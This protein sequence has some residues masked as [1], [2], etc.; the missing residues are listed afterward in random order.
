MHL[1][2]RADANPEIGTGHVM[3]CLALAQA[4]RAQGG[5][6]TFFARLTSEWLQARLADA[7]LA[8]QVPPVADGGPDDATATIDLAVRLGA[9]MVVID[10]YGFG[11]DYQ[12]RLSA[13]GL[14]LLVIDDHVYAPHYCCDILLNQNLH[15]ESLSYSCE[16]TTKLL[17][18]PRFALLREE[19]SAWRD[20]Q[21]AFPAGGGRLLLSLGGSDPQNVTAQ[22]MRGLS[23]AS[24]TQ[25][26]CRVLGGAA[27][28]HLSSLTALAVANPGR[29]DVVTASTNMPD[30][31]A[32]AD[33][34][35]SA[36]GSTCWELAFMGLPNLVITLAENQAQIGPA[37]A[38][39][40]V[41][42]DLGWAPEVVDGRLG[43]TVDALLGDAEK[44]REMSRHG[45]TLVDG[46]G[47]WRV[48]ENMIA[49]IR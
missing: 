16:P 19:F 4:W 30:E 39:R 7:G 38:A 32:Q 3:R 28:P 25:W 44:R 12:R 47:A 48:V 18:G 45:R 46:E 26:S 9:R 10:G 14:R 20:W 27:S 2:I 8:L 23:S 43:S 40:G 15:A 22:V 41:C 49:L 34:A 35:I 1:V 5:S 36:G 29:F 33:L 13:A 24:R 42:V 31:M 37:L 11:T 6:V 17:L 21:R